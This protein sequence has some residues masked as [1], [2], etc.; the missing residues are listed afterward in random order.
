MWSA[1][2]VTHSQPGRP[3]WADIVTANLG[4]ARVEAVR[5]EGCFF[6]QLALSKLGHLQ[7][8]HVTLRGAAVRGM[9]RRGLGG[10]QAFSWLAVGLG[11]AFELAYEGRSVLIGPA[12]MA[13]LDARRTYVTTF[14]PDSEVLWVRVPH[15]FVESHFAAP[16][17]ITIEGSKG[18]GRILFD[19]VNSALMEAKHLDAGQSRRVS[20]GLLALMAAAGSGREDG[21]P[22][23]STPTSTLRRVKAFLLENLSDDS[24]SADAVATATGLTVRHINKLFEREGASLM[25]WLWRQRLH[26]ARAA[27][28]RRGLQSHSIR[29]VAFAYG[30]KS[31]SHFSHAF[32][33]CF[34]HPPRAE[35]GLDLVAGV[36]ANRRR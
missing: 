36:G 23:P 11:G 4:T 31:A 29:S 9:R 13:I 3:C 26:A 6:G 16:A 32:R 20:N 8:A 12:G 24:L 7:I 33:R 35:A 30:F 27:L 25:R 19:A 1:H 14:A 17:Q 15:A 18:A 2:S 28:A 10:A 34:G 21:L 5:D 22:E